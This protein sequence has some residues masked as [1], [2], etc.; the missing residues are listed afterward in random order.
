MATQPRARQALD[1][2]LYLSELYNWT[3]AAADYAEAENLFTAAGD[4]RN[5]LYARLGRIRANVESDQRSLPHVSL[6]LEA[7]LD[8]NPFLQHDKEL[9]MF[10]LIVKGDIDTEVNTGAMREDWEEV[11]TLARELGNAKWQYRAL[12]QLGIAAFY[13]G[14]LETARKNAGTALVMAMEA[15][16]VGAQIKILTIL[17]YGLAQGKVHEQALSTLDEAFA[18]AS[19][20]PDAGYQ[21]TV[22]TLRIGSLAGI[23]RLKDAEKLADDVL[24]L[25][26][27]ENR[28]THEA[29]L[30]V[31]AS[32][33][34]RAQGN[35]DASLSYLRSAVVIAERM[36]L[37]RVLAEAHSRI[38]A[39]L[40]VN[41]SVEQA[42]NSAALAAKATQESGNLWAVPLRLQTLAE[43]HVAR[44][45]YAAADATYDRAEAFID[46]L[47]GRV[48][49]V[50]EKT[51]II[52][53]SSD[54]FARH[55]ALVADHLSNPM[56]AYNIIET[57][58]GRVAAD[59]VRSGAVA[60]AD[61]KRIER[62]I[63]RVRLKLMAARSTGE[64]RRIRNEIFLAEQSR[65]VTPG[66]S[67]LKAR[68][69]EISGVD[70]VQAALPEST[71][72]LEYVVANPRS[73]CV[74]ISRRS[75]RIV[76]LRGRTELEALI[77][78]YVEGLKSRHVQ[79]SEGR[80]L[81]AALLGPIAEAAGHRSI[82]V[83]RDGPLHLLPFEALI[84]MSGRY[85]VQTK[86][87]LYVPSATAFYL[88]HQ[89]QE[90]GVPRRPTAFLAVGGVPYSQS[91]LNRQGVSRG[92]SPSRTLGD[93]PSSM[94]EVRAAID[95]LGRRRAKVLS[96]TEATEAEFKS[97]GL[98]RYP[99]IHLAVHGFADKA[100]P[101]RA[102]LAM[103]SD[104]AKGEDGLLQASEIV[105]LRLK[106]ALVV[107]SACETAV[108]TLQGQDGVANLSRAFLF[109]GARNVVSTLWPIEDE[110]SLYIMKRFY[111]HLAAKKSVP[112]ALAAAKRDLIRT[113]GRD[114]RPYHWAAFTSEGAFVALP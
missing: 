110:S 20:T 91:L 49:T 94:D 68:S 5:A 7:E 100:I 22:Q 19:R 41:G 77:A 53:A 109:A 98:D 86:M 111:I 45:E 80:Q 95:A 101:D 70:R 106:A 14:D 81:Y 12:A 36:G 92:D 83:V 59:L 29:N 9:R 25:A 13:D 113:F 85:V 55:F 79:K 105:Q 78:P 40:R 54:I 10:C 61:A 23:G 89:Q 21:Y 51:A 67:I 82:V 47:I 17:G 28:T 72:L 11:Q 48:S 15:R 34:A 52:R 60:S 63:S 66:V 1:R 26:R 93:L 87:I 16:D 99:V 97:A 18:L 37:P 32:D 24:V 27:E 6:E 88:L 71:V 3:A 57:V 35:L 56:K 43:L 50:L 44:R 38:A 31:A 30:L 73:Y 64:V 76:P 58:R 114:A 74:V 4:E 107:L 112:L 62:E 2:A 102:A 103:L 65:W 84:D 104:A 69:H 96:G 46:A 42:V 108:G 90:S 33:V 8:T 75:V 39:I